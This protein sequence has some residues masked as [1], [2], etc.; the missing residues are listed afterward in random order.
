MQPVRYRYVLDHTASTIGYFSCEPEGLDAGPDLAASP[1]M[2]RFEACPGDQ[3]LHD[4]LLRKITHSDGTLT[5]LAATAA[6]RPVL[7]ALA[8]EAALLLPD[9]P[10]DLEAAFPQTRLEE[11]ARQTG[12]PLPRWGLRADRLAV[13]AWSRHYAANILEHR[14]LP[15]IRRHP[16]PQALRDAAA[17][18]E[19]TGPALA[20]L[21][22][23]FAAPPAEPRRSAT[24]TA[25][26]ALERLMDADFIAGPELRHLS[27]LS[28][29]AL[30]RRWPL[31]LDASNGS[32]RFSLEGESV[33]WGRGLSLA[34]ARVSCAMEMV[35]RISAYVSVRDMTLLDRLHPATLLKARYSELCAQGRPALDPNTLPVGLPYADTPLHWMEAAT[36]HGHSLL[37]PLQAVTLFCNLDETSLLLPPVSTGL[38]TGNT[39]AEAR[40]AALLEVLERDAEATTPWAPGSV[41]VL[42]TRD[43]HLNTLL[44]AYKDRGIAVQFRELRTPFGI[45]CYECFVVAQ[46]GAVVRATA[47]SL[48]ARRAVLSALTETPWPFPESPAS[49]PAPAKTPARDWDDLP[50]YGTGSA[51]G[52][53][54]LLEQLLTAHGYTPVYADLTRADLL[55]P[56]VRAIVPGLSLSADP[57]PWSVPPSRLVRRHLFPEAC[58]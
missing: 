49:A 33:S 24:E 36:C 18:P 27:S 25:A 1:A 15:D 57:D 38:A 50:D 56:V 9:M 58:A 44:Q 5:A 54:A 51:Q 22:S 17:L 2:A 28:P 13:R 11:L 47:A 29:I 34:D 42:T 30:L 37:V 31:Q 48:S 7:A 16:V 14:P 8:A 35:E 4:W 39:Q 26:L 23:G 10:P 45:P 55:F 40:L 3:F 21:R 19:T 52:D 43:P 6:K 53:L 32:V 46:D 12:L 20:G 41:F